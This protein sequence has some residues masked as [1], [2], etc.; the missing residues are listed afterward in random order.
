MGKK[1]KS[2][3]IPLKYYEELEKMFNEVADVCDELQISSP[4]ELLRVLAK[5]G[6]TDFL[7]IVEQRRTG[8]KKKPSILKSE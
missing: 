4:A 3:S 2:L 7:K 1:Q 8:R 5:L 6:K